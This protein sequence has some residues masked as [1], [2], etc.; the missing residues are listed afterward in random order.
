MPKK[1]KDKRPSISQ[2]P[3]PPTMVNPIK[4]RTTIF[5]HYVNMS[6]RNIIEV[7][8]IFPSN[9]LH[10]LIIIHSMSR[11]YISYNFNNDGIGLILRIIDAGKDE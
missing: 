1:G 7:I 2:N 6:R 5:K 8:A 4:N 11:K 10:K 3:Q 9:L